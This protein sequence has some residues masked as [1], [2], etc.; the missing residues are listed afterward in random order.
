MMAMSAGGSRRPSAGHTAGVAFR[1]LP[2][3]LAWFRKTS[4]SVFIAILIS[5]P[6]LDKLAQAPWT[7]V[8]LYRA[9]PGL[10]AVDRLA[11]ASASA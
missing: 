8:S 9:P 6:E 4:T 2:L 7:L 5:T 1:S 11:F 10:A 3:F